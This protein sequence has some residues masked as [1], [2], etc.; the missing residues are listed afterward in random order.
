MAGFSTRL[1]QLRLENDLLQK[2]L[3]DK[4]NIKRT[5]LAGWESGSRTPELNSA[6]I[7]ADYFKVSLDYLLGK[8]DYREP[9]PPGAWPVGPQARVPVLGVIRAGQPI[10]ADE[11]IIGYE[12]A[13]AETVKNGEFFFLRVAG[14]S[15]AP[16]IQD[17]YLVLVR[18]QEDVTDGDVTVV[19]VDGENATVKRVYRT[20]G[21]LVL[22]PDNPQYEPVIIDKNSV[23]IIGR[24][25]E[26]RFRL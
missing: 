21:T 23:R 17:G 26:G 7:L 22:R 1:K 13:D 25:V 19:I 11:N 9:L 2:E 3:A 4:V 24:V 12:Y 20:N 10:L 15:M 8:S 18:K 16:R 5:T 14:D 6:Q